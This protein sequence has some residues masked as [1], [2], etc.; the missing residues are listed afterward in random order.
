MLS[1]GR[2][3]PPSPEGITTLMLWGLRGQM[4]LRAMLA[5]A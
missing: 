2:I 4:V 3:P 5:I 1:E